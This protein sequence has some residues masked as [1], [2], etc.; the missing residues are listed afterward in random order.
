VNCVR[1]FEFGAAFE[2]ALGVGAAFELALGVGTDIVDARTVMP[3]LVKVAEG[4]PVRVPVM[5]REIIF[6][7]SELLTM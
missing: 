4:T 5:R 6:A 3:A 7:T 1:S 2:L